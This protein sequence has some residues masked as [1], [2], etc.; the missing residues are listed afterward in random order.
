MKKQRIYFPLEIKKTMSFDLSLECVHCSEENILITLKGQGK[1]WCNDD[2]AEIDMP[3]EKLKA[4]VIKV[5]DGF[6]GTAK[7]VADKLR[8]IAAMLDKLPSN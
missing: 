5:N 2:F 1:D 8:K 4:G 7:K 6:P 3:W